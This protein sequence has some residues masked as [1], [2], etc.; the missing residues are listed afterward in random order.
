MVMEWQYRTI[1]RKF[2]PAKYLRRG[3]IAKAINQGVSNF[4]YAMLK[5]TPLDEIIA[6]NITRSLTKD[7][8]KKISS[9]VRKSTQLHNDI[10]LE[11][12]LSQKQSC[13]F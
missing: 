6:G 4:H 8:L 1:Q 5:K 3:Q 12:M 10:M 9:E 2:R 7:V 11:L 13:D